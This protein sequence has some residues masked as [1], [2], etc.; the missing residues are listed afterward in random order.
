M[1]NIYTGE[2][3]CNPVPEW[4]PVSLFYLFPTE[5]AAYGL[6][7]KLQIDVDGINHDCEFPEMVDTGRIESE[8]MAF[9][10]CQSLN[11]KKL[12]QTKKEEKITQVTLEISLHGW[13]PKNSNEN[14]VP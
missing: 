6:T 13:N 9:Q 10:H 11:Y 8:N 7:K 12:P 3:I 2:I 1:K 14:K 5:D 4:K